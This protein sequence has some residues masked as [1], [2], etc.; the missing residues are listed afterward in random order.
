MDRLYVLTA[1]FVF[2]ATSHLAAQDAVAIDFSRDIRPI[3]SDTCYRCHGPDEE[4]LQADLRLDSRENVFADRDG[5]SILAAGDLKKSELWNRISSDDPDVKMPPEDAPRQLTAQQRDL[6]KRWIQQGAN[7][8][9]HWSFDHR[10]K[11]VRK[12]M[13]H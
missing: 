6:I 2:G 7:W 9:D 10:V 11:F 12:S 3:L 8:Q 13:T 5:Y 1:I 4:Q